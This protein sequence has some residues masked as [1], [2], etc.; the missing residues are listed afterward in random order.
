[1][2]FVFRFLAGVQLA[3][4]LL[5]A[6]PAH[7][8]QFT[9]TQRA[10]IVAVVRDA[11]KKD[12]SLLRDAIVALQDDDKEKE[13]T[14]AQAALAASKDNLVA[15]GDPI[16]GNPKGD[17]T[18]V[19]FFDVRCPYCRKMEPEMD[20]FLAGD[21]GVRLVYKDL[22]ILGAPSVLGTKALLAARNQNAY[23]KLRTAVMRMS[24]DITAPAIEAEARKLGLD[25]VRLMHDMED[26][27]LQ[28]KI[29]ENLKLAQKL[30]IQGTPAM[31]VG[32]EILPGAVDAAELKRAVSDARIAAK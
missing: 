12:P 18:I 16:G 4:L 1:M 26:P 28:K 15:P 22:P 14:A 32:G 7:A 31:I 8:D 25:T 30:N 6:M 17:V 20:S 21:K 3:G 2:T 5:T 27:A 11:L 10:E 24:R 13:R 9:A 19:E 29:D 23:E